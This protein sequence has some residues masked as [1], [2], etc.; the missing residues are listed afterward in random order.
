MKTSRIVVVLLVAVLAAAVAA[1]Y[2]VTYAYYADGNCSGLPL[3]QQVEG[4]CV[5][6]PEGSQNI[7]CI[8]ETAFEQLTYSSDDC[9]GTP[10]SSLP[11]QFSNETCSS[12]QQGSAEVKCFPGTYAPPVSNSSFAVNTLYSG[13]SCSAMG[14]PAAVTWTKLGTC[15]AGLKAP[16]SGIATCNATFLT[17]T[18]FSTGDCSG[19]PYAVE[20]MPI[21]CSNDGK[22][23]TVTC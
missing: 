1:D 17:A 11:T 23:Q 5:S 3:S 16:S 21:G 9:S 2:L 19:L 8:N 6:Y 12:W 18:S 22:V 20:Y 7:M 15:I 13:D 14:S 10:T 4:F